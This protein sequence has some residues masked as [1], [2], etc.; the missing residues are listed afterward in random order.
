MKPVPWPHVHPSGGRRQT[1]PFSS[2]VPRSCCD[3]PPPVGQDDL[4]ETALRATPLRLPRR[5]G[6]APSCHRRS[7]QVPPLRTPTVP[8]W[9]KCSALRR[10]SRTCRLWL[11]GIP[12]PAASCSRDRSSS[13]GCLPHHADPRGADRA[14][15]TASLLIHRACRRGPSARPARESAVPGALPAHPR[16]RT[17][18]WH[19]VRQLCDDVRRAEPSAR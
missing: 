14:R 11:T 8:C 12:S 16:S 2:G 13:G 18:A 4:G 17:G 15:A 5:A 1:P 7:T 19:V 9:T 3:G 10:F 6:C